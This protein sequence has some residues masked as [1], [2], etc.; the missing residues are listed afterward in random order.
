MQ[1][2][3]YLAHHGIKGQKWGVRRFQNADGTLTEAGKERYSKEQFKRDE[4]VYGRAGAKRIQKRVEK[5]GESVSGAR[6]EE[7]RRINSARRRAL[8]GGQIG[9]AIGGSLGVAGGAYA[10]FAGSMLVRSVLGT[11]G[12]S[13]LDTPEFAAA[14]AAAISTGMAS[15]GSTLGR[16]GGRAL[17]MLSGGYNPDRYQNG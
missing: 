4:S 7:A 3:F 1:D 15:V 5:K 2:H 11:N 13:I 12:S 14:S 17:G 6:S 10:G 8:V 16:D 9:A